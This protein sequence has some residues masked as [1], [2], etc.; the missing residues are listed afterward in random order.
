[1]KER[2]LIELLLFFDEYLEMEEER[3]NNLFFQSIKK[4]AQL[5]DENEIWASLIEDPEPILRRKLT[6]SR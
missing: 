2:D 6:F 5:Y 1:M 3:D 4:G